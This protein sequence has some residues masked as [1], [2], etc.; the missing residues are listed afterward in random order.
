MPNTLP[1]KFKVKTSQS[2]ERSRF[3]LHHNH[4]STSDFFKIMPVVARKVEPNDS[5]RIDCTSFVRLFP[6]PFPVFGRI[7]YYNRCF[8][9]PFRQIMEGFNEFITDTQY[10]TSNGYVKIQ[11]VPWFTDKDICDAFLASLS[12]APAGRDPLVKSVDDLYYWRKVTFRGN[13]DYY[14][15]VDNSG[16]PVAYQQSNNPDIVFILRPDNNQVQLLNAIYSPLYVD[17]YNGTYSSATSQGVTVYTLN[18]SHFSQTY[19][20]RTSDS[21]EYPGQGSF[22]VSPDISTTFYDDL[23]YDFRFQN[24]AAY[25]YYRFTNIG[26]HF[27]NVLTSL[28]YRVSFSNAGGSFTN[29]QKRSAGKLL[30]YLKVYLDWYHPSAYSEENELRMLFRGVAS[31]GRHVTYQQ[32]MLIAYGL[33]YACYERDYFTGAWQN[34]TG[35]NVKLSEIGI[36]DFTVTNNPGNTPNNSRSRLTNYPES[37]NPSNGS[38]RGTP[39]IHGIKYRA[40]GTVN[41]RTDEPLNLSY[42]MIEQLRALTN[43]SRRAQLTGN[44]AVDRYLSQ[45]GVKLDDD[46]VNRCYYI[47]GYHY[48]ADIMDIMSTADTDQ[49]ALGDYAGKGI[50]YSDAHRDFNF[51]SGNEHGFIIVVSSVV[52]SVGYVQG[53]DRENL[54]L[55]KYDFFDGDFDNLGTQPQLNEELFADAGMVGVDGENHPYVVAPD[56][57]R[58][59]VPRYIEEKIGFDNL[60]GDFNIPSRREGMDAFHLFRLFKDGNISSINKGF[61]IGEQ[62]Q[63]D[64]IFNNTSDDYDHMWVEHHVLID[65]YRNMKSVNDIYDFEH[66]DGKEIEVKANGTQIS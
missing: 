19:S 51:D 36:E 43:K 4:L 30:A 8:F 20:F 53:I 28:K 34:P 15:L 29:I 37:S 6:M 46:Q 33:D 66:S 55:T 11:S 40:E 64:R 45:Y 61:L 2:R 44:R 27:Y 18:D 56:G 42:Y 35:P 59:F 3:L 23:K 24:G 50:A 5:M 12:D 49:A 26:R 41:A 58:G 10:N 25:I 52:P 47:G 31:S 57:V 21:S 13:S 1:E 63:Y 39:S 62:K 65:A 16:S 9:V 48:D 14:Q 38:L 32:L 17:F 60:T 7:R 22:T 54:Q